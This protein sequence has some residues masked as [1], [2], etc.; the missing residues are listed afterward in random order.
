MI[1][2][3]VS[4]GAEDIATES[5]ENCRFR[6]SHCRLTTLTSLSRKPQ[7]I[8]ACQTQNPWA[9]NFHAGLRKTIYSET[10]RVMVIQGHPRSLVFGTNRKRVCDF[11]L[12]INSNSIGPILDTASE[13]LQFFFLLNQLPVIMLHFTIETMG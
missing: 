3:A 10:H 1:I 7:R 4:K 12:V 8:S 2:S 5:I 11:L 6:P 13:I 9:T